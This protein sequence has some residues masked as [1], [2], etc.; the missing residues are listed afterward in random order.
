M[1]QQEDWD[2]K[3][4]QGAGSTYQKV[5]STLFHSLAGLSAGDVDQDG[6]PQHLAQ[7]QQLRLAAPKGRSHDAPAV[8]VRWGR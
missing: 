2:S 4:H 3:R 6:H 8:A 5:C 1:Q 7:H